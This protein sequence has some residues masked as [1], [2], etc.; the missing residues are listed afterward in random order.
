M[1]EIDNKPSLIQVMASVETMLTM[2]YVAVWRHYV[3]WVKLR[4]LFFVNVL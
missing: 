1:C 4:R 3:H 2:S